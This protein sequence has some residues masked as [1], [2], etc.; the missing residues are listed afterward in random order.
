MR[1]RPVSTDTASRCS[2]RDTERRVDT[3]SLG[4]AV[5]WSYGLLDD[6]L[7]ETFANLSVFAGSFDADDAA[8]VC[9]ADAAVITTSLAQLVERS[10][11][12]RTEGRRY[13]LL[14]T[15]R[16]FGAEQLVLDGRDDPIAERHARHFVGWIE[17]ADMWLSVPG[18][19]IIPTID[20]VI[21]ELR[22]AFAWLVERGEVELAGRLVTGLLDYGIL[23]LR[24][25]V[26]AWSERVIEV[27][28]DAPEPV[29]RAGARRVGVCGL[30]GGR[31][32]RD[33]ATQHPGAA[34]HRAR[35]R[36][37]SGRGADDPRQRR[38]VRRRTRG[39]R[40]LV[41]T[42]RGRGRG[43]GPAAAAD[44]VGVTAARARLCR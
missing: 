26:L 15:L 13:V 31:R 27:D 40:D 11:V 14:E 35:R 42:R 33:P 25:D 16:A 43:V 41:P 32:R 36:R 24:P 39:V 28:P 22:S 2:S 7:K 30:D 18:R 10:L 37:A 34:R 5:S 6:R 17:H 12:M 29:C 19:P 44:G 20:A 38:A 9:A 21:P 3:R 8:A 4:A 23:R 1:S